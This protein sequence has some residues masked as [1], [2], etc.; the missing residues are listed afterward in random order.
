MPV[1]F[2]REENDNS[3]QLRTLYKKNHYRIKSFEKVCCPDCGDK[4]RVRD[5]KQRVVQDESGEK[6]IFRLRRFRCDNCQKLHTEIPD[7]IAPYKQYGK[8]VIDDNIERRMRL[9]YCR[10]FYNLEM[11]ES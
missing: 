4:M 3:K 9:F 1:L 5:S 10:C 11:E 8:N 6:Y 7:C 2:L